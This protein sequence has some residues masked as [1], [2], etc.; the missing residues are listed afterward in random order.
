M[1]GHVCPSQHECAMCWGLCMRSG[2]RLCPQTGPRVR[3]ACP[4]MGRRAG[5]PGG[6][7]DPYPCPQEMII[8]NLQP[9]TAYSITVAAYTMKGD[10]A[11]SKP[12]VVVTKGAGRRPPLGPLCLQSVPRE[13][14]SPCRGRVYQGG[15]AKRAE[16][17]GGRGEGTQSQR[18]PALLSSSQME[19]FNRQL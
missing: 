13:F 19:T 8:T 11:R 10:G 16:V 2:A 12:K 17:C 5:S 9:E 1:S 15:R 7:T 4:S 14:L 3:L 6:I 18:G